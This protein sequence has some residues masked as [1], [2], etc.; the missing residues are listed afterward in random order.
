MSAVYTLGVIGNENSV[1]NLCKA[2]RDKDKEVQGAALRMLKILKSKRS[3][4]KLGKFLLEDRT[5]RKDVAEVLGEIK[6]R[7]ALK[8][9]LMVLPTEKDEAKESIETAI[10]KIAERMNELKIINK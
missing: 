8:Y 10:E 7:R 1:D 6:D 2:M 9:L 5:F 4:R 3:V